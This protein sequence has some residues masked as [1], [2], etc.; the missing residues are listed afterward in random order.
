MPDERFELDVD[1]V[2]SFLRQTPAVIERGRAWTANLVAILL[3]LSLLLSLPL[4]MIALLLRPDASQAWH[5][6]LKNGTPRL[7]P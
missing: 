3:V 1:P 2:E 7:V 6:S 4:Y 5:W